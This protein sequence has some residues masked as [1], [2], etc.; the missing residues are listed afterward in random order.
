MPLKLGPL[1]ASVIESDYYVLATV[2]P[3]IAL[4][5]YDF[6][7]Y[8]LGWNQGRGGLAFALFFLA[9]EWLDAR[10][11]VHTSKSRT[12]LAVW[13]LG[14][15]TVSFFYF[16][17]YA[18][19][20]HKAISDFAAALRIDQGVI[21]WP[22]MWEY[23]IVGIYFLVATV[24]LFGLSAVRHISVPSV[25]A[26]G[27]GLILSLDSL[28]PY[29]TLGLLNVWVG[30]IW[31]MVLVLLQLSGVRIITNPNVFSERPWVFLYQN[32]LFIS[33]KTG[34]M[35]LAIYWPS[36]GIVSMLIYS[37]VIL[38]LL[39]KIDAPVRR[40]IA[41]ALIGAIGTFFVNVIRVFLI[42]YYVAFISIDVNAF[43]EVIGEILFLPWVGIFLLAVM[44]AEG[45]IGKPKILTEMKMPAG[46]QPR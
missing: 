34:A 8:V 22:W 44:R 25:Y 41:Y 9:L 38:T 1:K 37:M 33:G 43:H 40:K 14:L 20:F 3:F 16:G 11:I 23:I 17:V 7:S 19:G 35:T 46:T 24:A 27:M 5:F 29:D 12:G 18:L 45:Y 39:I 36:S 28:F 13:A 15:G 30:V 26:L 2:L 4:A 32:R 31:S 21:N 10:K 42:S 6:N